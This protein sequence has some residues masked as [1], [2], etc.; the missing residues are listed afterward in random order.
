MTERRPWE[1][2]KCIPL[3][4]CQLAALADRKV[5]SVCPLDDKDEEGIL[6]PAP[7]PVKVE[8]GGM[9]DSGGR[10]CVPSEDVTSIQGVNCDCGWVGEESA[11]W[12]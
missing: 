3:S 4:L 1:R 10:V 8:G 5:S 12:R 7:S 2:S 6:D 9:L 11:L